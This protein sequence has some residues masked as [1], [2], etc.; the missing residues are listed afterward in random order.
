MP[1]NGNG[2]SRYAKN[3]SKTIHSIITAVLIALVL[4]LAGWVNSVSVRLAV[5]EKTQITEDKLRQVI[6]EELAPLKENVKGNIADIKNHEN[7]IVVLEAK[8]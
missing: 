1:D 7:R 6:R 5:L 3:I 4:G 2:T 8:P